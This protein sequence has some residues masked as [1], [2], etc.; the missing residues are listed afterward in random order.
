MSYFSVGR[1]CAP[2]NT[3]SLLYGGYEWPATEENGTATLICVYGR[4]EDSQSRGFAV[5]ECQT[6]GVWQK[7]DFSQCRDSE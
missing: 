7:I 1:F 3:S 2:E 5:R 4:Q 6:G